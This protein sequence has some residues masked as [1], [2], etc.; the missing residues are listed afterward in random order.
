M[1][2]Y[3][4]RLNK[5]SGSYALRAR[6][7]KKSVHERA[8]PC[9]KIVVLQFID[10]TTNEPYWVARENGYLVLSKLRVT[11]FKF[12]PNAESTTFVASK[13]TINKNNK[14]QCHTLISVNYFNI[15]TR[16]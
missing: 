2:A 16:M 6:L 10:L 15:N 1:D 4:L 14:I 12:S 13:I 9:E 3:M 7:A 11:V 8:N 5:P